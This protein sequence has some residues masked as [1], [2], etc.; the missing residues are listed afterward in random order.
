MAQAKLYTAPRRP[1]EVQ[2]GLG[3]VRM[4]HLD[5]LQHWFFCWMETTSDGGR[6]GGAAVSQFRQSHGTTAGKNGIAPIHASSMRDS[7]H[8]VR[9]RR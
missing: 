9:V 6:L 3:Y 2:E 5:R 7:R 1:V 8:G 4:G